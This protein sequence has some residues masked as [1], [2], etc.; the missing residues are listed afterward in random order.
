MKAETLKVDV[1]FTELIE[2]AVDLHGHL[3]PFV[4]IGVK[5]G[6]IAKRILNSA[7]SGNDALQVTAEVPLSIPFSC[8]LDGIQI[9]TQCTVGNQKLK[10]KNSQKDITAYFQSVKIGKTLKISVN[11]QVTE[12]LMEKISKGSQNEKLA[13]EIAHTPENQLFIVEK[14]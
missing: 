10:I 5:M 13:W 14:P 4:V 8:V 1:D 11:P 12:T 9:A 6:E 7:N 2:K 3:G